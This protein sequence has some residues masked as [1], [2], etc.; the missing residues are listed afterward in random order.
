MA[1]FLDTYLKQRFS[2]PQMV[3]EWGYNL[4]DACQ[5]YSHDDRIGLFWHI[6][7][8]EVSRYNGSGG[9]GGGGL[10]MKNGISGRET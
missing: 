2:L 8:G 3:I 6:L 7:S 10:G 4:H 5:R 9:G 1:D